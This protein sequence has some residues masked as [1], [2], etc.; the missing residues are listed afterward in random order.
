MHESP[1]I[2]LLFLNIERDADHAPLQQGE[3][4]I[5]FASLPFQQESRFRQ[6]RL[7]RQQRRTQAFPLLNGPRMMPQTRCNEAYQRTGVK[8]GQTFRQVQRPKSSM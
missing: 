7:A 4:R 3:K 6:D 1:Q 2:R 8:Y 5:G